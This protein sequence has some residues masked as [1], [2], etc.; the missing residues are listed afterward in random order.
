MIRMFVIV[1]LTL[2]AI[3]WGT[4]GILSSVQYE[5]R[6]TLLSSGEIAT[7]GAWAITIGSRDS[8]NL[9][10]L[11]YMDWIDTIAA[12]YGTKGKGTGWLYASGVMHN[13]RPGH[14]CRLHALFVKS[15]YVILV[16]LV[17]CIY[18]TTVFVRGPLRRKRRRRKGLCL[19]CGYDLTGNESGKCPECGTQL[20]FDK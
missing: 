1:L 6:L 5:W 14:Y 16:A 19:K 9:L 18:P 2:A 12:P 7:V 10:M 15:Y 8:S 3:V 17:C 13:V 20:S 11:D 4:I